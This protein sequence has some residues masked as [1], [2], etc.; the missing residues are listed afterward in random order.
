MH[1]FKKLKK[2]KVSI[3][4]Y[5]C[6]ESRNDASRVKKYFKENGWNIIE[7][8]KEA[9]LILFNPCALTEQ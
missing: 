3:L 2:G 7:N 6:P 4:C 1:N 9:D 5:G 8:Y